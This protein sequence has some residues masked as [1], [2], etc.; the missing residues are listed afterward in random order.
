MRILMLHPH[1]PRYCPWTVRMIKLAEELAAV[2]HEPTVLFPDLE[3]K[4]ENLDNLRAQQLWEIPKDGPVKYHAILGRDR[5]LITNMKKLLSERDQFDLVHIQ[6][7]VPNAV[8]PG[9][10]LAYLADLPIHYD[11]DDYETAIIDELPKQPAILLRR[12]IDLFER[13]LPSLVDTMTVSSEGIRRM[14]VKHGIDDERIFKLPVG[15]DLQMFSPDVSGDEIRQ[16]YDLVNGR[17]PVVLY[18]G[19][20][21]GAH[22]VDLL[23]GAVPRVLESFPDARFMIVGGGNTLPGIKECASA[24]GFGHH[25]IFTGYIKCD[26]MPAHLAAADVVVACFK[27]T[28]VTRCKSPLKIAE[29]LAAGKP[30]VASEV[31]EVAEM[32][33]DAGSLAKPGDSESL[34][35]ELIGLLGDE[36]RRRECGLR[37][38]KRAESIYNWKRGSETLLQA[39]EKAF[40]IIEERSRRSG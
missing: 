16:R 15:A 10:F 12:Q 3:M 4:I 5:H 27:D 31:G 25:I 20:L 17:P 14:A 6:K 36:G 28:A 32:L 23:I 11:W 1:D 24:S 38:R 9:L 13:K 7:C 30:I 39:Y 29:Y 21:E 33:G 35:Q 22:S 37:A 40:T 19:Q 2:G 34:A 18:Q 26:E 8:L